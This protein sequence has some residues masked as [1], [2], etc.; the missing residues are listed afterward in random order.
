MSMKTFGARLK[1]SA[2]YRAWKRY[3]DANGEKN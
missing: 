2:P 3:G 1:A